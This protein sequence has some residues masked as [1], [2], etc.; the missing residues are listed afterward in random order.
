MFLLGV[1]IMTHMKRWDDG[2]EYVES[3]HDRADELVKS[4]CPS[5]IDVRTLS[6]LIYDVCLLLSLA[7]CVKIFYVVFLGEKT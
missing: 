1:V 3:A 7:F 5:S 6:S 2:M 4:I